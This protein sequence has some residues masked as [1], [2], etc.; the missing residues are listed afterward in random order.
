MLQTDHVRAYRKKDEL[1]LR[2]FDAKL[3]ARAK[4]IAAQYLDIARRSVG[5]ERQDVMQA[6]DAVDL[7]A[8]EQKLADGLKKLVL[9]RADFE[10]E[11]D[12]D[13][14]T[15]REEVFTAAATARAQ[16]TF[17]REALLATAAERHGLP[18]HEVERLLYGDLKQA[19]RLLGFRDCEPEVIVRE[20]ELG[21]V[22]AVLLK[23]ERVSASVRCADPS[24]YRH[25][26]RAL[27]F[28]RLLHRIAKIPD[29]GYLIEIDGPAS[30]FSST[31]KYG[32]QLA[33]VLPAIR[34][35]DAWALDAEVRWGKDRTRLHFRA[36]GHANSQREAL[37]LPE[38]LS[39]LLE[40]LRES[41]EKRGWSVEVADA[42][43]T[44]P[45]LGE[46]VPDLRLSK[47]DHEVFVEILGHWSRDAVWKRVEAAEKGLPSPFVFCCSSRLR[48]SEEVLPEEVPASLYVYKGVVSAKQV[49]DRAEALV[50]TPS[51]LRS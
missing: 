29:G 35:C 25:L 51:A 42:I 5:D 43:F 21:Q 28:H 17:D 47:R 19:Q 1:L 3:A 24:G 37:A 36:E 39:Q 32:L 14:A 40:R 26:F 30:L 7:E 46:L 48:V 15:L 8:R 2:S 22:Q 49:L 33:L 50:R 31:T 23:A 38:E 10:S 13:P 44:V 11:T 16:G 18:H 27:K 4:E 34:A 41:S 6:L 9:D 12:L 20:Y 45:G